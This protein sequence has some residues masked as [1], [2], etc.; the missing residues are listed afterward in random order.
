MNPSLLAGLSAIEVLSMAAH[1]ETDDA[2]GSG[3]AAGDASVVSAA[4]VAAPVS[5]SASA[6]AGAGSGVGFAGVSAEAP[7][8]AV[9]HARTMPA[10]AGAAS[11]LVCNA[12]SARFDTTDEHRTHYKSNWHRYN[13]KRKVKGL[14]PV[15]AATFD[16]T[17]SVAL[18]AF[19][20]SE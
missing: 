3:S 18:E 7:L 13:S 17:P 12:C 1:R 9:S 2:V 19:F 14:P 6:A 16:A 10:P 20:A 11:K 15:D 8:G 5:A 4:T